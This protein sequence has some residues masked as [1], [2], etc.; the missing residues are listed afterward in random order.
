MLGGNLTV[1]S[2]IMLLYYATCQWPVSACSYSIFYRLLFSWMFINGRVGPNWNC[3]QWNRC[4]HGMQADTDEVVEH[5]HGMGHSS[6]SVGENRLDRVLWAPEQPSR[7]VHRS[8]NNNNNNN[9]MVCLPVRSCTLRCQL[10][11]FFI[12]SLVLDTFSFGLTQSDSARLP[13]HTEA[14]HRV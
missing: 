4:T 10:F 14:H 13:K 6:T 11:F 8:S 3:P 12:F 9:S 2:Y 7:E 1:Y 5:R